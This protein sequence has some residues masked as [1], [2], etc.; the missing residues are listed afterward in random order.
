MFAFYFIR[1]CT[2]GEVSDLFGWMQLCEP[3]QCRLG[4]AVS[5]LWLLWLQPGILMFQG[6]DTPLCR[7]L[8]RH[9]WNCIICRQ[10][11]FWCHNQRSRLLE[12]V[13]KT[14]LFLARLGW[15]VVLWH[16]VLT[17][18]AKPTSSHCGWMDAMLFTW[19]HWQNHVIFLGRN[20]DIMWPQGCCGKTFLLGDIS[21]IFGPFKAKLPSG[22]S[23]SA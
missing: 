1:L 13:K 6:I 16:Q 23:T 8:I 5:D 21:Q 18:I 2:R 10:N 11:A 14:L 15:A 22:S 4:F 7:K 17:C 9:H 20:D 19:R 3:L 12:K